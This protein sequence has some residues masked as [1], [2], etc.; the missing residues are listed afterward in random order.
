MFIPISERSSKEHLKQQKEAQKLKKQGKTETQVFK[1]TMVL[2][3][4][5]GECSIEISDHKSKI[6][7]NPSSELIKIKKQLS[8]LVSA[9]QNGEIDEE[10]ATKKHSLIIKRKKQCESR[11][12]D[13]YQGKIEKGVVSYYL[14]HDELFEACPNLRN[15]KIK[16]F[17]NESENCG[18]YIDIMESIHCTS[19]TIHMRKDAL[20]DPELFRYRLLHE[21]QHII[22]LQNGWSNGIGADAFVHKG[23]EMHKNAKLD[24]ESID[25]KDLSERILGYYLKLTNKDVGSLYL[26]SHVATKQ[27]KIAI[28]NYTLCLKDGESAH[29]KYRSTYGE[30][31]AYSTGERMSM[32]Y[33]ERKKTHPLISQKKYLSNP[34]IGRDNLI[35]KRTLETVTKKVV[36][37]TK[38]NDLPLVI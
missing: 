26:F 31:Q 14:E 9:F 29:E 17:E 7:P 19:G 21:I 18:G 11:L 25:K 4:P 33:S 6:I 2:L 36:N 23:S 5:D 3:H 20:D 32:S 35:D 34:I 38:K 27:E 12:D 10:E 15:I 16:F 30:I 24:Y 28:N 22:Q 37:Y 1:K 8:E 13:I